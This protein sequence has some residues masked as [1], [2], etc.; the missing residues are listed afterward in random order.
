[1]A[2]PNFNKSGASRILTHRNLAGAVV[3]TESEFKELSTA[4]AS[5]APVGSAIELRLENG[6][7]VGFSQVEMLIDFMKKYS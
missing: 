4:P 5:I 6:R 2:E 3:I 7:V 1:M